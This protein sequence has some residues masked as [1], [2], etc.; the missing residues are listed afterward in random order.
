MPA[1][2]DRSTAKQASRAVL[3]RPGGALPPRARLECSPSLHAA[4]GR[5]FAKRHRSSSRRSRARPCVSPTEGTRGAAR[6][7]GELV[8]PLQSDIPGVECAGGRSRGPGRRR[9]WRS[10]KTRSGKDLDAFFA[11]AEP[12][13]CRCCMIREGPPPRRLRCHSHSLDVRRRSG[14]HRSVL[15]IRTMRRRSSISCDGKFVELH[16]AGIEPASA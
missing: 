8:R 13:A 6:L 2:E 7:L 10:T 1:R 16:Q 9:R 5:R 4:C 14:R 15:P 3:R 12:V 11:G